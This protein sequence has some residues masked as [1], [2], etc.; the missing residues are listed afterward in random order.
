MMATA[1][2]K[3]LTS[4]Q[5]HTM[6]TFTNITWTI[7]SIIAM[8][9]IIRTE[10]LQPSQF[11]S[12]NRIEERKKL[13]HKSQEEEENIYRERLSF[14]LSYEPYDD[15]LNYFTC[16]FAWVR[17]AM[18]AVCCA[19]ASAVAIPGTWK[20]ESLECRF[21]ASITY[22]NVELRGT[23]YAASVVKM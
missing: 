3:T 16:R 8:M 18:C 20:N 7:T 10:A 12:Q 11:A 13:N 6:D 4:Q 19:A 15:R 9:I 23:Q 1:T 17:Y 21:I 2:T 22:I 5:H 14:R